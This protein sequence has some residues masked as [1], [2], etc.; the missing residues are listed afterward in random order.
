M[1]ARINPKSI[2]KLP[3]LFRGN[4]CNDATVGNMARFVM[5]PHF[6]RVSFSTMMEINNATRHDELFV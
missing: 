2:T 3:N 1:V 4:H 6:S 5:F